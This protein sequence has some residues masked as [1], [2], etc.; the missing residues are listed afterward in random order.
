MPTSLL[1]QRQPPLF[2]RKGWYANR[3][4]ATNPSQRLR[5]FREEGLG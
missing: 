1:G 3:C 2:G 4:R 5:Q